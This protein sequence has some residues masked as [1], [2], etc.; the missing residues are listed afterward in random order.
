MLITSD[1]LM[2]Q[3][4]AQ[5]RSDPKVL[6]LRKCFVQEL[7]TTD[8]NEKLAFYRAAAEANPKCIRAH[9]NVG[10]YPFRIG[11]TG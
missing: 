4:L 2:T 10:C 3:I 8:A 6:A 9:N 11:Q 5:M 7:L 1:V